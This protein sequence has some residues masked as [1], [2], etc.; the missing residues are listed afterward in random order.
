[1]KI[2]KLHYLLKLTIFWLLF[3]ALFRML[4][5]LYHHAKIPDGQHSQTTLSFFYALPLDLYVITLLLIIPAILWVIQ[6][7]KKSRLIHLLNFGYNVT[8]IVLVSALCIFNIKI[9]GEYENLLSTEELAYLLYPREAVTFLSLWSSLLLLTAS[10][11]FALLGIRT[12]NRYISNFSHPVD[13]ESKRRWIVL[14]LPALFILTAMGAPR[15]AE[16]DG[17][18]INYSGIRINNDISTN[19]LW[20]LGHSFC[21]GTPVPVEP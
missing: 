12:Y 7:Y 8:M 2:P 9:Y 5:I 4:F 19:T 6:Q 18:T 1:M 16:I 13:N 11:L 17:S 3:F 21:S 15:I 14:L 10:G 20:Y